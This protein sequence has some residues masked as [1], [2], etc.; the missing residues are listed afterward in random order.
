LEDKKITSLAA[1][2]GDFYPSITIKRIENWQVFGLR[3][4]G[5]YRDFE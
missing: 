2:E 5:E 1:I 3:I 4:I